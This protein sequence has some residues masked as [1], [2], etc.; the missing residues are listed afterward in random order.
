M[1]STDR[2]GF[3]ELQPETLNFLLG[4]LQL[5]AELYDIPR[6]RWLRSEN[7]LVLRNEA[8]QSLDLDLDGRIVAICTLQSRLGIAIRLSVLWPG[9]GVPFNSR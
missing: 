9:E 3:R 1:S 6:G 4:C 5:C 8:T 2:F 7:A